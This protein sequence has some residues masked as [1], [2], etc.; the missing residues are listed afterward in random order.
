M[1]RPYTTN[2]NIH[3]NLFGA[4]ATPCNLQDSI[5]RSYEH[6]EGKLTEAR[7]LAEIR[8]FF[9]GLFTVLT[10]CELLTVPVMEVTEEPKQ[11]YLVWDCPDSGVMSATDT[12]LYRSGDYK[13]IVQVGEVFASAIQLLGLAC[14]GVRTTTS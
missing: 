7:G 13:N 5:L 10:K 4:F 1:R 3:V 6:A 12:F 8:S 11:V 14:V 2:G 9:E